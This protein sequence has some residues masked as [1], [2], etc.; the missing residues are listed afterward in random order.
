MSLQMKAV[1][2]DKPSN[3]T[4]GTCQLCCKL[5]P[6]E[7][8]SPA[9]KKCEHQRVGKGCNIYADRPFP[10]RV[11]SC[12]W[13]VN[14]AAD[15]LPRPDRAHY[16]IDIMPDF[17]HQV[18]EDGTRIDI[19]VMQIWVDPAFRDAW[20]EP[21]CKSY[22]EHIAE[23]NRMATIVRWNSRDAITVFAPC[24]S[25]DNEWHVIEAQLKGDHEAGLKYMMDHGRIGVS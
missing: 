5:L 14:D 18:S 11:W 6:I 8:V 7:G 2:S 4:C 3:R 12:R 1:F 23:R 20:Q 15:N 9:G 24:L 22:I 21:Q 10:C 25:A 17:I 16:V 19:Q 13:L